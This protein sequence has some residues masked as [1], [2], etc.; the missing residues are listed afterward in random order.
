MPSAVIFIFDVWF[1]NLY[2]Q[3]FF[4]VMELCFQKKTFNFGIPFFEAP[5]I[6]LSAAYTELCSTLFSLENERCILY[7]RT[8][9]KVT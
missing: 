1:T 3:K 8:P 2:F 4:M 9:C 6:S 5:L 7:D